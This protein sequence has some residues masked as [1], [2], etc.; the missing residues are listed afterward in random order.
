MVIMI[1][2]ED[3]EKNFVVNHENELRKSGVGIVRLYAPHNNNAYRAVKFLSQPLDCLGNFRTGKVGKY[4]VEFDTD[5]FGRGE[6]E[7]DLK[8]VLSIKIS[9]YKSEDNEQLL[10]ALKRLKLPRENE[11]QKLTQWQ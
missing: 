2:A 5:D 8:S 4:Q 6:D 1:D 9:E 7:I 11:N 3:F 10:E